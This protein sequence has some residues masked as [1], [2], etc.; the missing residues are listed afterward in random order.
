[1]VA[2]SAFTIA[3]DCLLIPG[4]KKTTGKSLLNN[5]C[6]GKLITATATPWTGTINKT[7]CSKNT[8]K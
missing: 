1:M 8:E 2:A 5:F 6:G 7:I 3:F 4:A